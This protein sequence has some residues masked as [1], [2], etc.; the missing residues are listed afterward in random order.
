METFRMPESKLMTEERS[1]DTGAARARVRRGNRH[2]YRLI[3]GEHL[4]VSIHR[5]TVAPLFALTPTG[6]ALW[7]QME[8]WTT[9]DAL[10][11]YLV[12]RY[13]V[14]PEDARGDVEAFLEQLTAASALE[15]AGEVGA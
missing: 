5:A 13:A 3:A 15:R 10:V 8:E 1:E 11:E 2:V 9:V 7:E 12:A 4:L 6:A 14:A